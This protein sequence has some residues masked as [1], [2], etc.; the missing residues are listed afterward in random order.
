M[1]PKQADKLIAQGSAITVRSREYQ[2]TF[3]A[4][5]IKRDRRS[6]ETST[7]GLFDRAD[8]EIITD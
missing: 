1:T 3:T 4:V 2:E 5:F 8:L 6:I 7:G